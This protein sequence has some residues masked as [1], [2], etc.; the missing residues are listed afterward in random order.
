MQFISKKWKWGMICILYDC[1]FADFPQLFYWSF[2]RSFNLYDYFPH[3]VVKKYIDGV[4]IGFLSHT[5]VI[6]KYI[7]ICRTIRTLLYQESKIRIIPALIFSTM[8][9]TTLTI[10][11][12]IRWNGFPIERDFVTGSVH[13][14]TKQ[15]LTAACARVQRMRLSSLTWVGVRIHQVW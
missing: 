6:L 9:Y 2:E 7:R 8:V 4:D 12:Q 10:L 3:A 11:L 5:A 15:R 13:T 14:V 1:S